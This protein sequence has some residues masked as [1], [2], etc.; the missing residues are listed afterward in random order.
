MAIQGVTVLGSFKDLSRIIAEH[1]PEAIVIAA[2][3]M[4]DARKTEVCV[5]CT[6]Y[7]VECLAFHLRIDT[8]PTW[9]EYDS[10]VKVETNGV[11][12]E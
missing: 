10:L 7:D 5:E 11:H 1:Q 8:V 3:R 12:L 6:R 2:S 4:T 9:P